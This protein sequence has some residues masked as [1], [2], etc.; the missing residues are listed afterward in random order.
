MAKIPK[1]RKSRKKKK[2]CT[3]QEN[4]FAR[5]FAKT[6]S[7]KKAAEAAGYSP[8]MVRSAFQIAKRDHVQRQIEVY[9]DRL[10]RRVMREDAEVVQELADIAF[11]D[12]ASFL[13]QNDDDTWRFKRPDELTSAQ[14]ACI[15]T[16]RPKKI[17]AKEDKER[18][19]PIDTEFTYTF[20]DKMNALTQMG[21]HFGLFQDNV[22]VTSEARQFKNLPQEVLLELRESMRVAIAK[23]EGNVIEGEFRNGES[24]PNDRRLPA[25]G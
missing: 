16:I 4:A 23:A 22:H 3:Q 5:H 17:Y 8:S 12:P 18:V 9:T 21:R 20:H 6:L 13:H 2:V 1:P 19:T 24:V 7:P 14:R 15:R 25:R 11:Q 10:T